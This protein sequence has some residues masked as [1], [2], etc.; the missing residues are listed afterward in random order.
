MDGDDD[1]DGVADGDDVF[2]L[3]VRESSILTAMVLAITLMRSQTMS[4]WA[5]SDGD[6]IETM[7]TVRCRWQWLLG[8]PHRYYG[9]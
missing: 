4:E 3:D 9:S 1:N 7:L 5:D 8:L 2:P 6:G